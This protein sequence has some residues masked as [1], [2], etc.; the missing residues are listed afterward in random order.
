[1][2]QVPTARCCPTVFIKEVPADWRLYQVMYKECATSLGLDP[3]EKVLYKGE[4][5]AQVSERMRGGDHKAFFSK[6]AEQVQA[7][8]NQKE[9]W[10]QLRQL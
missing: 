8:H 1:M 4:G 2:V 3:T 9:I 6:A 7:T 5:K 10:R